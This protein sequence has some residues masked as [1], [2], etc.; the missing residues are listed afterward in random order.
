MILIHITSI[1]RTKEM[2]LS[3]YKELVGILAGKLALA[4]EEDIFVTIV[5]NEPENWTF[6]KGLAQLLD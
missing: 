5:H 2:K 1:P 4:R 6:G 3:L